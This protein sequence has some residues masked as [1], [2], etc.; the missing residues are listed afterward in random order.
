MCVCTVLWGLFLYRLCYSLSVLY[1]AVCCRICMS[2]CLSLSLFPCCIVST[3]VVNKRIHN[4]VPMPVH[5]RRNALSFQNT[6]WSPTEAPL[7]PFIYVFTSIFNTYVCGF[8]LVSKINNNNYYYTLWTI[9]RWQ[10][11]CDH[12]FGKSQSIFIIFALL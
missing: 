3:V 2:V 4:S 10:Y 12:N 9:K 5:H 11:I 6:I 1:Y 8:G 7:Q